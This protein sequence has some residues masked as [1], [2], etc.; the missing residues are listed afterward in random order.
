MADNTKSVDQNKVPRIGSKS[1]TQIPS[2]IQV[3]YEPPIIE[4]GGEI[5]E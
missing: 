2:Q 5:T 1:P 4:A 3:R